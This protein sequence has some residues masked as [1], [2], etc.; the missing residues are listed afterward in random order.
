MYVPVKLQNI[1]TKE[2]IRKALERPYFPKEGV[3]V[4]PSVI[5]CVKDGFKNYLFY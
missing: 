3:W 5:H 4:N 1:K 2:E